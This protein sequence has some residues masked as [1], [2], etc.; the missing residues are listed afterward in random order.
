MTLIN[1]DSATELFAAA[2]AVIRRDG[3]TVSPRGQET[4]EVFA[5]HLCLS[6]PRAR[7][8]HLPGRVVNPA[9]AAAE[10][11][12]ILSGSDAPWI[13]EYNSKLRTY[14]DDGVLRGAYGPRLRDWAGKVDQLAR[15]VETLR[16]DPDSRRAVIQLY[17]PARDEN[18][19]RDVPCTL[20]FRFH[21]RDGHLVMSTTMRSQDVWLGLPYDLF[22]FTV[23]HEVMAGWLGVPMGEYHHHV[24]SLHL[25]AKNAQAATELADAVIEPAQDLPVLAVPWGEF[26]ATL[27]AMREGRST[28]HPG[29]DALAGTM[30]AYRLWKSGGA[31][32]ARMLATGLGGVLG[33][34]L[35]DW[36]AHL[37]AQRSPTAVGSR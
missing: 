33:T 14:A 20:G 23:L 4:R 28:G 7:L 19:N 37:R 30:R 26:D 5:A 18:C 15:V 17:D 10:A 16:L 22:T 24:D 2:V 32:E 9:F 27:A 1:A 31:A 3:R 8:V 36:F 12:W 29:W 21:L 11:V 35:G 34:S 25:Y 13:Y 6:R